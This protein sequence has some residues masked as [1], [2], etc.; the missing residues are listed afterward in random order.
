MAPSVKSQP[1]AG[2]K[3]VILSHVKARNPWKPSDFMGLAPKPPV[4][5]EVILKAL[6]P[7]DAAV[8]PVALA[9]LYREYLI[10]YD[11]YLAKHFDARRQVQH[12]CF[13]TEVRVVTKHEPQHSDPSPS[14][15]ANKVVVEVQRSARPSAVRPPVSAEVRAAKKRARNRRQRANR[16]ARKA[17]SAAERARLQQE[18]AQASLAAAKAEAKLSG[19]TLVVSK[20]KER[21]AGRKTARATA[22]KVAKGASVQR[23]GAIRGPHPPKVKPEAG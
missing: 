15:P 9:N 14:F 20:K 18:K 12:Y 2:P 1:N 16:S 10:L 7:S 3:R 19:W 17:A 23:R 8:T 6:G 5:P 22:R 21:L 11:E 13:D 4:G